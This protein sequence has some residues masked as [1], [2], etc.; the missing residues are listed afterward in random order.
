MNRDR[1][2][3]WGRASS[4]AR[5]QHA[6]GGEGPYVFPLC[7]DVQARERTSVNFDSDAARCERCAAR[8]K[9][10]EAA[11]AGPPPVVDLMAALKA[12]LMEAAG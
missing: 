3:R 12:S 2:Y 11:A 1:V 7:L 10:R 4:R 8:L 5:V 9:R 6:W